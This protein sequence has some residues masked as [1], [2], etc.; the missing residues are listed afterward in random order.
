MPGPPPKPWNWIGTS[1]DDYY[2]YSLLD[3][4]RGTGLEGNDTIIGNVGNDYLEGGEG[5]DYLEGRD[6]NDNLRAGDGND[7]LIGGFGDDILGGDAGNDYLIGGNGNNRLVGGTGNDTLVGG[8]D[9]DIYAVDSVGDVVIEDAFSSGD[10]VESS[11]NYSLGENLENLRI[12][13]DAYQGIGNKLNN[14]LY[15]GGTDL[16][17]NYLF[18]AAG[19]DTLYANYGNDTLVGG[20]GDDILNGYDGNNILR[21]GRGNDRLLGGGGNDILNGGA[22]NDY[23]SAFGNYNHNESDTLTGGAG[24]DIFVLGARSVG[25]FNLGEGYAT[26]TDFNRVN[27]DQIE[28]IGGDRSIVSRYS[29]DKSLNFSGSSALDT[30]IY[31]MSD[32]IAV[33]QDTTNIFISSDFHFVV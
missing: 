2:A 3:N 33:V 17:D 31:Y 15:C 11:I 25:T 24:A 10:T 22:G 13:G 4:F 9:D 21:G 14:T 27:S 8:E 30:G 26:I 23:L 29:L 5:N 12:F 20:R 6:G 7:Y 32:L 19:N 18:G 16:I 1:G 28:V